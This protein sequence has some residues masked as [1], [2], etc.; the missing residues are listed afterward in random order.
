VVRRRDFALV[1]KSMARGSFGL[2]AE[3]LFFAMLDW[4]SVVRFFVHRIR[5]ALAAKPA[6]HGQKHPV[7]LV[8]RTCRL[9]STCPIS[10]Q[11]SSPKPKDFFNTITLPS[12]TYKECKR[13]FVATQANLHVPGN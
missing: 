6:F 7:T 3:E 9:A 13:L 8:K 10:T 11:N 2:S 1:A 5:I 4:L 12:T